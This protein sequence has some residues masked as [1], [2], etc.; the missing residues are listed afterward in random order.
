M[1]GERHQESHKQMWDS[2]SKE[3]CLACSSNG[4]LSCSCSSSRVLPLPVTSP[5]ALLPE[6]SPWESTGIFSQPAPKPLLT[7]TGLVLCLRLAFAR[8]PW[9]KL[10][11]SSAAVVGGVVKGR[12]S[13]QWTH[14]TQRRT[15]NEAPCTSSPCRFLPLPRGLLLGAWALVLEGGDQL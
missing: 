4:C 8:R 6:E 10:Q 12:K 15:T 11:A 14:L 13:H 5:V 7:A 9:N 1:V 3:S 2:N